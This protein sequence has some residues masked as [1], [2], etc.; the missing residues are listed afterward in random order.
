MKK[1]LLFITA[2]VLIS[3][4]GVKK[5]QEALNSGNYQL[6]MNKAIKNLRDNKTKKGNQEYVLLL[7]EAFAK[8]QQREL[9]Q[10]NFFK[11]DGN[12]ANLEKIYN[13]YVSLRNLQNQIKPLLPLPIYDE[14]RNASFQFKDYANAI[15]NTKEELANY[16]Y[17]NAVQLSKNAV[18][19]QDYRAAYEDFAYLLKINPGFK[20]ATKRMEEAR[21]QGQDYVKVA[22]YNATEQIIPQRLEDAL[23][24]FNTYGINDFWT[25]YH[26]NPLGNINY[27]YE[28]ALDFQNIFIS[29][30][31]V[32]EKQLVKEKI[33]KD[34]FEYVLDKNGNV[35]K[36]SLGN[37]I[38]VDKLKTV[39]CDF[40]RFTQSKTAEIGAKISFT[41]L[42]T[43]QVINSY[44]LSSGFAFEHVYAS[45]SG[46]KRAL[47]QD[48]INLLAVKSVPF[49]SN[50]Q[51][52]FDA[53]E[54]LKLRLKE[55]VKRHQFN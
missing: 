30:E 38:K 1:F 27:D 8:N 45:H 46:D 49:P 17:D 11:K 19:K 3:C 20:D 51:M 52:V 23:L 24:D 13:S 26:S 39:R 15:V 35:A 44:P 34:G 18:N 12:P 50:E 4:G 41:D 10:I 43:N 36:D 40:Y 32:T 22:L 14:N 16:L 25:Q 28:M 29:P 5:T 21:L 33:V 31:Q 7:E 42:K 48:L 55:I 37:D 2:G 54:D 47:E 9:E 6:A 53:G